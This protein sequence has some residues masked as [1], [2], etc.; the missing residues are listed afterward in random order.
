M[1]KRWKLDFDGHDMCGMDEVSPNDP[2]YD[3]AYILV[4]DHLKEVERLKGGW[5]SVDDRL[6]EL[7][8]YYLVRID[9][10][11]DCKHTDVQYWDDGFDE[12]VTHWMPLPEPP[13]DV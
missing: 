2:D 12:N 6:P 13:G 4:E 11:P 8:N 9:L 7:C 1:I 3:D 5:I 10:R